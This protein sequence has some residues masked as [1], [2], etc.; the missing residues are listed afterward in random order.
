MKRYISNEETTGRG[1]WCA[2]YRIPRADSWL[3]LFPQINVSRKHRTISVMF[4]GVGIMLD[5][6]R[7]FFLSGG[8]L[9]LVG[10]GVG[11]H[12]GSQG[13]AGPTK[14]DWQRHSEFVR[15]VLKR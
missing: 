9:G 1:F 5:V 10:G 7:G 8:I 14:V 15:Q 6:Y 4:L 12:P 13:S 11:W 3:E 2:G